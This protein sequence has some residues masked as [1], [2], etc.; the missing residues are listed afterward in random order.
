MKDTSKYTHL[1]AVPDTA[2]WTI[3]AVMSQQTNLFMLMRRKP[4]EIFGMQGKINGIFNTGDKPII[5]DDVLT[6]GSSLL[7]TVADLKK[8]GLDATTALVI[9]DREQGAVENLKRNG[10]KVK[11]LFKVTE[12]ANI[13]YEAGKLDQTSC[14]F[15]LEYQRCLPTSVLKEGKSLLLNNNIRN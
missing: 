7:E 5:L 8:E 1:C 15:V 3:A 4:D 13:L 2:A 12:L 6:N 9:V 14:N 11:S 10:I